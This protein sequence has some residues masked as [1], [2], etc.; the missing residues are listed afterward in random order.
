MGKRKNPHDNKIDD[1]KR[2]QIE[3]EH[4]IDQL[5]DLVEQHTRTRRHLE[6]HSDITELDELQHTFK[7]QEERE[8][9]IDHLKDIIIYGKHEVDDIANLQKNYVYTK[10][11]LRHH[12]AHM[13]DFTLDKTREKQE[14]RKEQME[15]M[16]HNKFH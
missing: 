8:H 16:N 10:N 9:R 2:Y 1:K 5:I 6:Q 11:Y 7:V 15:F 12:E 13:D 14:H 4:R 3:N